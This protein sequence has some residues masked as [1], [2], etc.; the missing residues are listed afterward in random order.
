M[1]EVRHIRLNTRAENY[2]TGFVIINRSFS[3]GTWFS[4]AVSDAV[5]AVCVNNTRS[6]GV[7]KLVCRG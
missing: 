2:S 6:L 4:R 7:V 1:I 5:V 3:R